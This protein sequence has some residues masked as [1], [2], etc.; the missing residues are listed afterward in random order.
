MRYA[1]DVNIYVKSQRVAE[2][3]LSSSRKFLETKLKLKVN[4]TKS[5]AGS[6]LKLKFLGFALHTTGKGRAGIRIHEKSTDR[7]KNKIRELTRRNQ[8]R[9]LE[10]VL[11]KLRQYTTGWLNYYAIADIKEFIQQA[12][13]WIKRKIRCYIRKQW[14][15]IKTRF[16]NLQALGIPRSKAWEW[17]NTRRGIGIYPRAGY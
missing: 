10:Y 14:K 6:P 12:N 9:S 15:R 8:G 13:G 2:W 17:V 3:V 11:Q 16:E 7:F 1:D 5:K 4:E